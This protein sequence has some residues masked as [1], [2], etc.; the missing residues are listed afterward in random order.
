MKQC[1]HPLGELAARY[2]KPSGIAFLPMPDAPELQWALTWRSTADSAAI[3]ALA[4]TI[5]DFGPI[6]L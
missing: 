5:A 3:R 1:V 2:N 6:Q 4:R